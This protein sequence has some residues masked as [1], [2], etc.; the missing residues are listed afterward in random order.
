MNQGVEQK[1]IRLRDGALS[2]ET[3]TN[4]PGRT[5]ENQATRAQT[6]DSLCTSTSFFIMSEAYLTNK[7]E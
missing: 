2:F 3:R 4:A 1:I 5:R 6:N 7:R